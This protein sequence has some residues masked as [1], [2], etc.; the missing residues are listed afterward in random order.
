MQK[1]L[2]FIV[3]FRIIIKPGVCI[4]NGNDL[5][6]SRN[7]LI[8]LYGYY[9]LS[10]HSWMYLC[11]VFFGFFPKEY[12]THLEIRYKL[13]LTELET[14]Y[15]E[16]GCL[17]WN[18]IPLLLFVIFLVNFFNIILGRWYVFYVIISFAS[19]QC[20]S[21]KLFSL[22]T[23]TLWPFN[24]NLQWTLLPHGWPFLCL[25][26]FLYLFRCWM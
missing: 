18:L 15:E 2:P 10:I 16:N 22:F 26:R 4:S 11:G 13:L 20:S 7:L 6:F 19:F 5:N 3:Y 17:F 21:F 12:R 25:D 9:K 1:D 23:P 24:E 8:F 14:F